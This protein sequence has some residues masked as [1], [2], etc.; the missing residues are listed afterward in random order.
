MLLYL[1]TESCA[2]CGIPA[3]RWIVKHSWDAL[4]PDMRLVRLAVR[5]WGPRLLKPGGKVTLQ[6]AGVNFRLDISPT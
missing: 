4:L 2:G 6:H 1:K 5:S 3:R